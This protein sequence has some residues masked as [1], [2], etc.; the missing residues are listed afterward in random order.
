V[1]NRSP[2]LDRVLF[3]RA[4]LKLQIALRAAAFHGLQHAVLK[5]LFR[6]KGPSKL[7]FFLRRLSIVPLLFADLFFQPLQIF[8]L[9]SS[10]LLKQGYLL[11]RA[12]S[13]CRLRGGRA[14]HLSGGEEDENQYSK[15]IAE[16]VLCWHCFLPCAYLYQTGI[17]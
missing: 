3:R 4:H 1:V 8:E 11:F 15:R 2:L 6:R 17:N 7:R 10:R 16:S 5:A 14:R 9:L 13:V 12:L